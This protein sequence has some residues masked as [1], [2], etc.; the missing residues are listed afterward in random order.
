MWLARQGYRVLACAISPEL[1]LL[2]G[3]PPKDGGPILWWMQ[4]GVYVT[5]SGPNMS[6]N[7]LRRIDA[8]LASRQ[9][10]A[11]LMRAAWGVLAAAMLIVG[12][13]LIGGTL[14]ASPAG[15]A[16]FIV[17][18]LTETPRPAGQSG[19][20]SG[21]ITAVDLATRQDLFSLPTGVNPDAVPDPTGTRLY[22]AGVSVGA[23]GASDQDWLFAVDTR[24]GAELW[25]V[26]LEDRVKYLSGGPSS[27]FLS[28][29]GRWLLVFSSPSRSLGQYGGSS[30]V[31]FWFQIIDAS[32]GHTVGT[33]AAMPG[34]TAAEVWFPTPQ[35]LAVMCSATGEVNQLDLTAGRLLGQARVPWAATLGG[36]LGGVA[37]TVVASTSRA[38]VVT[39]DRRVA[40]VGASLRIEQAVDL[41]GTSYRA[42]GSG[43]LTLAEAG[44]LLVYATLPNE[45][46]PGADTLH[47]IDTRSW[48]ERSTITS[49]VPLVPGWLASTPDGRFVLGASATRRDGLLPVVDTVQ[50]LDLGSGRWDVPLV[51][52]G[53]ALVRARVGPR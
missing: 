7:D 42:I 32:T 15:A 2:D 31:P 25:R 18:V 53:E 26:P 23:G 44:Q 28:P 24:T 29:N 33:T 38:L 17:Y 36:T 45:D 40:M 6:R 27:L 9:R 47:L 19:S 12:G 11:A 4:D 5:L 30:H 8:Y 14:E 37:G 13:V 46:A 41:G 21:R 34:C 52:P 51:R 10:Q 3:S 48:R 20:V 49:A 39:D 43:M 35:T 16:P 50:V 1:H 22:A